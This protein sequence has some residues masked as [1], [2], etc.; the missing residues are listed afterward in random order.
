MFKDRLVNVINNLV[1]SSQ[2]EDMLLFSIKTMETNG[3]TNDLLF[4]KEIVQP[5]LQRGL[6]LIDVSKK[7]KEEKMDTAGHWF[8][9]ELG[10][11]PSI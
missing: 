3:L 4:L 5:M 1:G 11:L 2:K 7:L 6:S 8:G 9:L 10:S